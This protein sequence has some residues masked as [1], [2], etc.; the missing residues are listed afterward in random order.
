MKAILISAIAIASLTACKPAPDAAIVEPAATTPGES[1]AVFKDAAAGKAFDDYA[2]LRSAL[3]DSDAVAAKSAA[4]A[5]A[6][7]N[8]AAESTS[9]EIAASDDI[10]V[11]REAFSR[12]SQ[13]LLPIFTTNLSSG[14]LHV[15]HCP[16]ALDHKG[17]DWIS[18][19]KTI[20]NPYF[21]SA[22]L[23]CG[24]VARDITPVAAP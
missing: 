6:K 7:D 19:S 22:M 14:K 12:L 21:G 10:K 5:L 15:I 13:A 23:D 11:Q 4:A 9:Q 1:G 16:M 24:E 2:K 3:V 18:E 17:A 8:A 20:R